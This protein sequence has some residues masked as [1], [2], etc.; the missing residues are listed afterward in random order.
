MVF[1][2]LDTAGSSQYRSFAISYFK[3]LDVA[4]MVYDVS[5]AETLE[6]L[7]HWNEDL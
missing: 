5:R 2:L 3:T 6:H 7:D 4:L 1:R